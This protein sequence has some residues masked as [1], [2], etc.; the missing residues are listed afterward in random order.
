MYWNNPTINLTYPSTRDPIKDSFHNGVHCLFY[1]PAQEK[2]AIR[3][4]QRLQDLCD[5]ANI[6]IASQGI[7]GFIE[8]PANHYDIA[9]LVKLN[10]WVDDLPRHGSIKP[11]LLQY[12]G[13]PLLE[14]GTGESRLRALERINS[15][16]NVSAFISTHVQYQDQFAHLESITT[17]D[18]FAKLCSAE[19]GQ[20]F[21]F[22]LTDTQAPYGIDWYEYN[23]SR[24]SA[25]TPGEDYC[26]A[27]MFCY[28]Q[29][30]PGTTFTP[31]WFDTLV[32]WDQYKNF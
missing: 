12:V 8:E 23:S 10:I 17:F 31:A 24:T 28:L 1:N 11:M 26:V 30:H 14:S 21:L 15:I 25:V 6:H 3:T 13:R 9:N 4:N 18:Q 32:N 27:V 7:N 20:Q 2:T 19:P 22:R 16:N 29:Q 5:W